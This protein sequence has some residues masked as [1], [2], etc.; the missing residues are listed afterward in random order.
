MQGGDLYAVNIKDVIV[1]LMRCPPLCDAPAVP[2]DSRLGF[3]FL[4]LHDL[5]PPGHHH[6]H[7]HILLL[8]VEAS[9]HHHRPIALAPT[10]GDRHSFFFFLVDFK[11]Q[12]A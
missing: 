4:F 8:V 9:L 2:H 6:H 12:G 11:W 7:H 5:Q 3:W 10:G 1:V